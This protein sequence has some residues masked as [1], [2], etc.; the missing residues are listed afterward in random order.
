MLTTASV[1]RSA[2]VIWRDSSAASA[3][4]SGEVQMPDVVAAGAGGGVLSGLGVLA[5]DAV[6]A[7]A[8]DGAEAL[9]EAGAPDGAGGLA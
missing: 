8:L 2:L 9:G 1:P 6:L 7:G 5:G 4:W 3:G